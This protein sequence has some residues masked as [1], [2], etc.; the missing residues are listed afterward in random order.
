MKPDPSLRPKVFFY[1]L[2]ILLSLGIAVGP[3]QKG[4]ASTPKDPLIQILIKK[5]I[6]TEEE[7]EQIQQEARL[8]E[9]KNKE[10]VVQEIRKSGVA[11]PKGL[12][13][14]KVGMLGYV[15][16][17]V[18]KKPL[19]GDKEENLNAFKL[20]RGYLTIKKKINPWL[21][22]RITTDIHQDD[23]EDWKVRL[24][25]LYAE[26]K[27][28]DLGFLTDMKSEIG[29]GHIPWLDFE[30]HVNPYRCQGTMAIERAG[31]F[32]SA[33]LGISLRG[34]IGGRLEDAEEK[35]GN[36]HYDGKFGSWHLGIYNGSGYHAK[37]NN[38][39]KVLE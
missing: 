26:L 5:G 17:S 15:D 25:Y 39:N 2:F 20:T 31:T 37:E 23:D 34:N 7:A 16:Y 9:E 27:P 24:K 19:P 11:V 3:T 18:G 14:I 38:D 10:D 13:G 4:Y 6:L 22:V 1:V 32:N 33:D 21:G 12:K 29:M 30:E 8:L 36:H 35:T 28:R